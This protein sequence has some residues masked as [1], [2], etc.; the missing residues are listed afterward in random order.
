MLFCSTTLTKAGQV[1]SSSDEKTGTER[2]SKIIKAKNL[3][4]RRSPDIAHYDVILVYG[5]TGVIVY[6]CDDFGSANYQLNNI[7]TGEI[8]SGSVDTAST[9]VTIPFHISALNSYSFYIDFEDGSWCH[10]TWGID[11]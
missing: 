2:T 4:I 6:F 5:D 9:Y 11:L 1:S 10:L 7:D 8:A 3:Q